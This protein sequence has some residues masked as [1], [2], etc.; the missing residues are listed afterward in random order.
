LFSSS[1]IHFSR[2]QLLYIGAANSATG[3]AVGFLDESGTIDAPGPIDDFT[4]TTKLVVGNF[5]KGKFVQKFTIV[6]SKLD[7]AL[8]KGSTVA[9]DLATATKD[10]ITN[11]AKSIL[12]SSI[13][14]KNGIDNEEKLVGLASNAFENG[15]TTVKPHITN[16]G[17]EFTKQTILK[18][19]TE[20]NV[21]F[22]IDKEGDLPRVSTFSIPAANK[23]EVLKPKIHELREKARSLGNSLD[24]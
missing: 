24:K 5:I 1:V 6:A 7:F 23:D 16:N 12:R 15:I 19:G 9:R 3:I 11:M 13:L 4:R 14:K 10:E 20:V 18:D 17:T 8:G 22:I 2:N 21:N